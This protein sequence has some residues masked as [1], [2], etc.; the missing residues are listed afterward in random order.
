MR[1]ILVFWLGLQLAFPFFIKANKS[2][3]PLTSTPSPVRICIHCQHG[4][5]SIWF[6]LLSSLSLLAAPARTG[7]ARGPSTA[8]AHHE[9][10]T[11][12][13]RDGNR[14]PRSALRADAA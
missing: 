8:S 4:P 3:R 9:G 1:S 7:Q 6:L 13:Q 14:P 11:Q 12:R 2:A 5:F 10:E